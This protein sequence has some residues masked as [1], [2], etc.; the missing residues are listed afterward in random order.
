[1]P[2]QT[3]NYQTIIDNFMQYGKTCQDFKASIIIGSRA[4]AEEPADEWSDLDIVLFTENHESYI[5]NTQWLENIGNFT[6][7]FVENTPIADSKE[8]RVLFEDGLDVDFAIINAE[9]IDRL[10]NT[11]DVIDVLKKGYKVLFDKTKVFQDFKIPKVKLKRAKAI[12]LPSSKEFSEVVNDFWY[13]CVWSVKKILRGE[14]WTAKTCVDVYLKTLLLKVIEWQTALS[15]DPHTIWHDGRF[16]EK[17]SDQR[18][19]KQMAKCF[20]HYE[21]DDIKRALKNTMDLF[22]SVTVDVC[23]GLHYNNPVE[24]EKEARKWVNEHLFNKTEK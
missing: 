24:V 9:N 11:P 18:V 13:H 17:W 16:F 10:I 8:R 3:T 22:S 1:M 21:N 19:V 6:I 2:Q 7:T 23:E 5:E 15:D 14:L 20:A 4:R 12:R